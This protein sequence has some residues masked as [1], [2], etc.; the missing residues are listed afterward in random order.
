MHRTFLRPLRNI[1]KPAAFAEGAAALKAG[2][3]LRIGLRGRDA[4][5]LIG[6]ML[7][8][9]ASLGL[10]LVWIRILA[11]AFG[12]ESFGMLG[13]LAGFFAGL[14]LGA[15]IFHRVI[16]R[17]RRPALIYVAVEIVI[18]AYALAGPIFM[19]PLTNA[20]PRW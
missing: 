6:F 12:S 18:A 19:L 8:G 5:L 16:R 3:P 11:L 9:V 7:S 1:D 10:E 20:L 4:A 13:V 17:S 2:G 14:T 15:A